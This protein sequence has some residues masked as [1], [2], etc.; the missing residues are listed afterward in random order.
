VGADSIGGHKEEPV[1]DSEKLERR[2]VSLEDA[3]G[4]S[5]GEF[6]KLGIAGLIGSLSLS[7]GAA[8]CAGAGDGEG[9]DSGEEE[10]GG[11]GY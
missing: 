10:D 11:G 3:S 5:R 6:L 4:I 1:S 8:G 9:T 2:R 7:F